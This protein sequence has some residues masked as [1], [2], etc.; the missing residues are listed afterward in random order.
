[1]K[2]RFVRLAAVVLAVTCLM[3]GCNAIGLNVE[4]QLFPPDGGGK[5]EAIRAAL[6]SYILS[7]TASGETEDYTLKYPSDGEYLS[8]FITLDQVKGRTVL[9]PNKTASP[10][11]TETDV[12]ASDTAIA[13]YRRNT[14]NALVHINLLKRQSDDSWISVADIEGKG[15]AVN[16]VDFGDLNNDG[17]PELLIG[18][19]LYNTRDSRVSIYNLGNDLTNFSF[20]APYTDLVIADFTDDG[21]DDLL[22]LNILTGTHLASAQLYS[23]DEKGAVAQ[24]NIMLDSE[25]ISFGEYTVAVLSDGINGVFLDCYKEQRAMITELIYWEDGQLCAPLCDQTAQLNSV[26]T[27]ELL[28]TSRDIDGDGMMEWPVTTRMPGFEDAET[29]EALWRVEWCSWNHSAK[30]LETEFIGLIPAKDSYMLRL[31]EEWQDLPAAYTVGTRTLTLYTDSD[32]GE[33]LFRIG[34]FSSE[35][36]L[37]EGYSLLKKDNGQCYAVCISD[38]QPQLTTED[39]HYL[40]YHLSEEDI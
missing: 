37:P 2:S 34:A 39:F 13:F 9:S 22:L 10:S 21:A 30:R 33:W 17:M 1:M 16:R 31:R 20:V 8:A 11:A 36:D 26:T 38:K 5:Q 14:E 25:I 40:F 3:T 29:A 15:E 7:H 27:R 23:F 6:N 4:S 35:E 32:S 24:G 19:S 28:I 18:W 12:A